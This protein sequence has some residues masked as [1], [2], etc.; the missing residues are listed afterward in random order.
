[1]GLNRLDIRVQVFGNITDEENT[2]LRR[3]NRLGTGRDGV[4]GAAK[5]D[6]RPRLV[7]GRDE[8]RRIDSS[9]FF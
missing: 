3:E 1:M 2:F 5:M 9:I 6:L 7:A 4:S 8:R